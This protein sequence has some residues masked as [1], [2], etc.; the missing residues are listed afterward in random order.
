MPPAPNPASVP[1]R[2]TTPSPGYGLLAKA[3]LVLFDVTSACTAY[4][5]VSTTELVTG[6]FGTVTCTRSASA[7][8]TP[9]KF[10]AAPAVDPSVTPAKPSAASNTR[11]APQI[12]R[13][14]RMWSSPHAAGDRQSWHPKPAV[15]ENKL[16]FVI[17]SWRRLARQG[18][19]NHCHVARA[20]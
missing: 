14:L 10:W 20:H 9:R 8:A 17:V 3:W 13:A 6:K 7:A 2:E 12:F 11:P 18:P 4:R 15:A 19:T 1:G 16:L 5:L